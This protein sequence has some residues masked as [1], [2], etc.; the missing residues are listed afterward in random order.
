MNPFCDMLRQH[1]IHKIS[2]N[3]VFCVFN[4]INI[5]NNATCSKSITYSRK[6]INKESNYITYTAQIYKVIFLTII[7]DFL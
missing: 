1:N 6:E 3:T 7:F 2:T 4:I 5:L